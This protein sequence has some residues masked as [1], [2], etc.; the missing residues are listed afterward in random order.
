MADRNRKDWRQL[1]TAAAAELD[2]EELVMLVQQ[3]L[4][5]FDERNQGTMPSGAPRP[6]TGRL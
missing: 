5:A 1:C 4:Q 3:I 6:D 2:P